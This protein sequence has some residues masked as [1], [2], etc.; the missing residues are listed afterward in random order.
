MQ[1]VEAPR[2]QDNRHMNVAKLSAQRT[3]HLYNS[4][5]R[6]CPW[7]SFLL[8]TKSTPGPYSGRKDYVNVNF[9]WHRRG[10]NPLTSGGGST[11]CAASP[12]KM[13]QHVLVIL[14]NTNLKLFLTNASISQVGSSF[15]KFPEI[16]WY[17]LQ[18]IFHCKFK[19]KGK[20]VNI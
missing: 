11:N 12:I 3:G 13:S 1:V 5:P 2:F 8:K 15:K 19:P 10:S 16:L 17:N 18:C 9:H 6:T 4:P 7:H 20:N 14:T